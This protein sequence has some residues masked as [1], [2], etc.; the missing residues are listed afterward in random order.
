MEVVAV[1]LGKRGARVYVRGA[2]GIDVPA[3]AVTEVDPT[4]AGDC[5]DAA[6]VCGL[7]RG[8]SPADAAAPGQRRWRAQRDGVRAH[9][10]R[11]L[12]GDRRGADGGTHR[13]TS[14]FC[15]PVSPDRV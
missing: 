3:Y 1:K 14:M 10:G 7:L 15:D 11:H 13:L 9:G 5:F 6:F 8:L 4:G 12:P 2:P